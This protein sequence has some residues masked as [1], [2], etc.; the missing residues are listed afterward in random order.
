MSCQALGGEQAKASKYRGV[1]IAR[2]AQLVSAESMLLLL[3]EASTTSQLGPFRGTR[4]VASAATAGPVRSLRSI[5][6]R[7]SSLLISVWI[8]LSSLL[9]SSL[10]SASSSAS[11]ISRQN[12]GIHQ[13]SCKGLL[14]TEETNL[15]GRLDTIFYVPDRNFYIQSVRLGGIL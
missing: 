15:H 4:E 13:Q 3:L 6:F 14:I 11:C 9:Y 5:T 2:M 1:T 12:E 8:I 10:S 7:R